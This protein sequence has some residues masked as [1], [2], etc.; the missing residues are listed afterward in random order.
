MSEFEK[1]PPVISEERSA[2]QASDEC[3]PSL[4]S[5]S[6]RKTAFL[7]KVFLLFA[8]QFAA[9]STLLIWTNV[10]PLPLSSLGKIVP[11]KWIFWPLFLIT[12]TVKLSLSFNYDYFHKIAREMYITDSILTIIT[13]LAMFQYAEDGHSVVVYNGGVIVLLSLFFFGSSLGICIVCKAFPAKFSQF[14]ALIFAFLMDYTVGFAYFF[15]VGGTQI[16]QAISVGVGFQLINLYLVREAQGLLK[17]RR[18]IFE[19]ECLKGFYWV[20]SDWMYQFWHNEI[21]ST[22][23]MKLRAKTLEIQSKRAKAKERK[24]KKLGN[25]SVSKSISLDLDDKH[26]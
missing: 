12:I 26:N 15:G 22:R 14:S 10:D 6:N 1:E 5:E 24:D 18:K 21:V 4:L 23:I 17:G 19:N 13:F 8:G 20:W 16:G 3:L 7:A 25:A 11:I 2:T 9:V